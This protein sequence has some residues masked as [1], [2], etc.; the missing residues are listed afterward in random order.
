MGGKDMGGV[1]MGGFWIREV[2]L[3]MLCRF[4]E[5]ILSPWHFPLIQVQ[6]QFPEIHLGNELEAVTK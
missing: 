5:Y 3:L 1:D 2:Q 6:A 4:A